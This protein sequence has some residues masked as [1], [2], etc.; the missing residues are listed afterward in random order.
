MC[1]SSAGS[2]RS[3]RLCNRPFAPFA[4]TAKLL[5]GSGHHIFVT[6]GQ[7]AWQRA[8][9]KAG[10]LNNAPVLV[11]P[12]HDDPYS[13]HWPV[14]GLDVTVIDTGTVSEEL[15]ALGHALLRDGAMLVAILV[16]LGNYVAIFR[17]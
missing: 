17:R 11:C 12:P 16:D 10:S 4:K 6:C 8:K 15:E 3:I 1:G 5:P 13:Y 7:A 14:F 2:S 9:I